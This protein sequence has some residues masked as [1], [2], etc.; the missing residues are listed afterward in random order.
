MK[1]IFTSRIALIVAIV[2]FGFSLRFWAA[3]Q[4]P[5]DADEPVYMQAAYD[6]SRMIR[7][8]D[9][10][11]ILEYRQNAEHPPLVKLLYSLPILALP[12]YAGWADGL[13]LGR[14]VSVVFGS[15]AV[16]L[17]ALIDP[18]AGALLAIQTMTVKY[19]A[20]TYLEAVPL[21]AS[22]AAILALLRSRTSRGPLVWLSAAALGLLAASKYSYFP[23]LFVV[24]FLF[25]F[26]KKYPWRR[27]LYYLLAATGVFFVLDPALW[28]NPIGNLV[29]S[30]AF[31]SQYAQG[32]HVAQVGYPWYQPL[33]WISK[34]W[35]NE[36]HPAVFFFFSADGIIC[37]LALV[38]LALNWFQ[39][40]WVVVWFGLSILFLLLWPTK[41]PQY[42]LVLTPALC[43]A[44]STAL[45]AA[46]GWIK[47][48]EDY[49]GWFSIMIPNPTRIVIVSIVAV[50]T[51]LVVFFGINTVDITLNHRGWNSFHR[52]HRQPSD[53]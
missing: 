38:G 6:Y 13:L 36:W 46:T 44:A 26:E 14:L 1:K 22:L 30:L 53:Q 2:L 49:W 47:E 37:I 31:H 16:L 12:P 15:L 8:G 18:L 17:L 35:P 42:T 48:Q 32:A 11:S 52:H 51:I 45:A 10:G 23:I 9:W 5:V 40:R 25:V 33:L 34:S 39:R 20:E 28:L 3:L 43:L 27:L 29:S 4:L 21:F 7:A 24:G 19:T 50:F 41:W